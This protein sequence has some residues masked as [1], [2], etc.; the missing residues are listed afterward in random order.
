MDG[1]VNNV[2]L[3]ENNFVYQEVPQVSQE[4]SQ[5]MT[6][7]LP[8]MEKEEQPIQ[9]TMLLD[10]DY[11]EVTKFINEYKDYGRFSKNSKEIEHIT[12]GKDINAYRKSFLDFRNYVNNDSHG[13]DAVDK[14]NLENLSK[15]RS[16]GLKVSDI[17]DKVTANNFSPFNIDI[18]G[19]QHNHKQDEDILL[20]NE[21]HY[22]SDTVNNGAFFFEKVRGNDNVKYN[23]AL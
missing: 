19:M 21:F 5:L 3:N 11:N 6:E 4:V 9:E 18:V 7:K 13:F 15:L 14:V 16:Q 22:D 2:M 12:S 17:Y 10:K 23:K 20:P 8:V 1:N